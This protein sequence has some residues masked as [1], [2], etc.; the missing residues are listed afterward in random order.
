MK[1]CHMFADTRAELD[2]MADAIGVARKWIQNP[3]KGRREHYDVCLSKRELAIEN[4]A[5]PVG[6]RQVVAFLR[7]GKISE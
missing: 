6:P 7:T 2:A 1:M 3:G 5:I 4:G